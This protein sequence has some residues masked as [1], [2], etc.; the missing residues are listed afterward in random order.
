MNK[1]VIAA[2]V[3]VALLVVGV[4]LLVSYANDA[5]ERAFDGARL[6]SVLQV[7]EPIAANTKAGDIGDKVKTVELP[8]SAIAKGALSS[9]TEVSG[10]ATTTDLQPGEQVLASRFAKNGTASAATDSKTGLPEGMQELTI[11]FDV[12]RALGGALKVG[13]TVGVVASYQTKDGDGITRIVQ[14]RVEILRISDGGEVKEGQT[15]G[16]QLVTFAVKTRDAG[17]IVNAIEFGKVYLTRQNEDT[18]FGQGG[19]ISRDDVTNE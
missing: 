15:G 13:D 19:S 3:A 6:R 1:R 9:L 17:K 14:N 18:E 12:A 11:P 5:N 7:E 16:T 8:A 2:L 10:L 4:V